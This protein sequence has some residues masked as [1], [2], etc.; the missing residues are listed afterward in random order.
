MKTKSSALIS[1]SIAVL[2]QFV[3]GI[4]VPAEETAAD[5]APGAGFARF[6]Q[7]AKNGERLNI[8]FFGAS[9]TWGANATDHART[10]YRA[11][12][13][14]EFEKKYPDAHFKF[15]DS[16]IGGTDSTLAVFRVDRDVLAHNPDLVFFESAANDGLYGDSD[17]K[18]EAYEAVVRKITEKN[19]PVVLSV[20]GFKDD[21]QRGK[22][23][24]MKRM[25]LHKKISEA[26]GTGYAN[27]VELVTKH[28]E[29][30]GVTADELWPFDPIHPCDKGYA[31][32]AKAI[33]SGYENAVS[34]KAAGKIP[35]APVCGSFFFNAKRVKLSEM[36]GLPEGWTV[37]PCA[38]TAANYDWLMSRWL[39][40]VVIGANFKTVKDGPWSSRRETQPHPAPLKFKV[41]AAFFEIFGES[42]NETHGYSVAIDG[43]EPRKM[44]INRWGSYGP[45]VS[46]AAQGL[47]AG[48]AHTIEIIP[49]YIDGSHSE[50][51]IE[52]ICIAGGKASVEFAK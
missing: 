28:I 48:T 47:D 19:I 14:D 35:E 39:D 44:Q 12:V 24:S 7:R 2:I 42:S 5:A 20:L 40:N 32:F 22:F 8:V 16:A 29:D 41:D 1:A 37:S 49:E 11:L 9:L 31:L 52:S 26:Y 27:A 36:K 50:F 15:F 18:A 10:S 45:M 51:R 25:F 4:R 21:M 17:S 34:E 3:A 13:A 6:D 46:I 33:W 23:A 30:G 43:G 38:L